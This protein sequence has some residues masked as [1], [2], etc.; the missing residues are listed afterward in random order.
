MAPTVKQLSIF[1]ISSG[2]T[3]QTRDFMRIYDVWLALSPQLVSRLIVSRFDLLSLKVSTSS[4]DALKPSR[5]SNTNL[6]L[7]GYLFAARPSM[8][9]LE[10]E[11]FFSPLVGSGPVVWCS[12]YISSS[13]RSD[14]K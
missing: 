3:R 8:L 14:V 6:G 5:P 13:R 1:K 10:T 11:T 12:C 4:I 7:A 9:V 2:P